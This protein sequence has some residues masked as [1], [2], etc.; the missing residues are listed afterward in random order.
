MCWRNAPVIQPISA[1]ATN[2]TGAAGKR[3]IRPRK[4]SAVSAGNPIYGVSSISSRPNTPGRPRPKLSAKA[5]KISGYSTILPACRTLIFMTTN[6][7]LSSRVRKAIDQDRYPM[8]PRL[9]PLKAAL[10][11]LDLAAAPKPSIKRRPLPEAPGWAPDA[12]VILLASYA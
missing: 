11:K 7:P 4:S 5:W 10:A 8:S 3:G 9:A 1:A 12:A 2:T 6:T